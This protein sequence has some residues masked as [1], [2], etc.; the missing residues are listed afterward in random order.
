MPASYTGLTHDKYVCL[1]TYALGSMHVYLGLGSVTAVCPA[2]LLL[3]LSESGTLLEPCVH[4]RVGRW[5]W[6]EGGCS[7]L[8]LHRR[9]MHVWLG[10]GHSALCASTSSWAYSRQP[11]HLVP[12]SECPVLGSLYGLKGCIGVCALGCYGLV[13][14]G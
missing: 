8:P 1:I 9:C 10:W 7:A 2:M 14:R 12:S 5:G 11:C 6:G 3:C 13:L 4:V